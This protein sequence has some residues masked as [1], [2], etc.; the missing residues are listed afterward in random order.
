MRKGRGFM[1]AALMSDA[2]LFE[3]PRREGRG[4]EDDSRNTPRSTAAT[5][6]IQT[7]L[8]ED[9]ESAEQIIE[10]SKEPFS[11]LLCLNMMFF[12]VHL[13]LRNCQGIPFLWLA[14]HAENTEEI[15]SSVYSVCSVGN[16]L[17]VPLIVAVPLHELHD[18]RD[19]FLREYHETRK[20]AAGLGLAF[21]Y[22]VCF[23]I[24]SCLLLRTA[25]C[26]RNGL[27]HAPSPPI[28]R[29][30]VPHGCPG[31]RPRPAKILRSGGSCA[32]RQ[33]YR[34]AG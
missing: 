16:A 24:F 32:W 34:P 27:F 17:S 29:D 5:K 12:S 11:V 20:R 18:L 9:A 14:E 7:D 8:Q 26:R 33:L 21:G 25:V 31:C 22:F 13:G 23:V 30:S 6:A 15:R 19:H 28:Q 2:R 1:G 4:S 3:K 10:L